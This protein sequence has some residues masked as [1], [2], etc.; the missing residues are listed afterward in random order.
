MQ[1]V[2]IIGGGVIG[3]TLA[4]ELAGE[5]AS[6]AVLDKSELGKESSWAGAGMLPPGNLAAAK[7]AE[8]KLRAASH[9]L[10]PELSAR[11]FDETGVDNEYRRSGGI[12]VGTADSKA[13]LDT[14]IAMWRNEGVICDAL[15]GDEMRQFEPMLNRNLV[16]G[17]RLPE[18]GH[19]RN[20]RH[21]R[22]LEALAIRRGVVL[23]PGVAVHS[24]EKQ[25]GAVRALETSAGKISGGR[26]VVAL[27]AWSNDLLRESGFPIAV[28]PLRGQIVLLSN[29]SM[30]IRHVINVGPRYLVPRADGRI[31]VGATEEAVGFDK[32]TTVAGVRG[33]IEFAVELVPN[34]SQA[35]VEKCWAGLRP[36]SADGLPYLGGIPGYDNLFVAA[37]HFRAG[38]QLSPITARLMTELVLGRSTSL[39][40]DDYS[41]LRCQLVSNFPTATHSIH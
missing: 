35:A 8:A 21:L 15:S 27:G 25:G 30:M 18:L 34:L 2:I 23:Q 12:E 7:T 20:P 14:E 41:P 1:D 28:R 17:Y 13:D 3:L 10:W 11:L 33:L 29:P 5:G 19:V 40:L 36:Q 31:L 32:Q 9:T 6:V 4:C 37:G 16:C 38:L 39:P 22:A 24:F 26:F